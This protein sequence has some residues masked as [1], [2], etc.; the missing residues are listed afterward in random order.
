MKALLTD[1]TM[2]KTFS[3]TSTWPI[4]VGFVLLLGMLRMAYLFVFPLDLSGDEAYYWDWGRRPAWCYYSKPPMIAWLMHLSERLFGDTG[5]GIRLLA[6]ILGTC[7]LLM[8]ALL[9]RCMF[10]ARVAL[11]AV[12]L[13]ALTPANTALNLFLTIDAPLLACW[14]AALYLFWRLADSPHPLRWSIPLGLVL[15]LGILSKQMMLVFPIMGILFLLHASRASSPSSTTSKRLLALGIAT[16]IGLLFLIPPLLWNAQ[17]EWIT[18]QHT[19]H[20]F[21][22]GR[23]SVAKQAGRFFEFIGSQLGIFSPLTSGLL[24][25]VSAC[26]LYQIFKLER[27]AAFLVLFSSPGIL[28]VL[29]LATRQKVQPN[30]PAVYYV[31]AFILLAALLRSALAIPGLGRSLCRWGQPAIIVGTVF[32][33][34]TY[35]SPWI[36]Q[37]TGLEGAKADPLSRLRGWS[38]AGRVLGESFETLPHPAETFVVVLGHRYNASAMAHYLPRQPKVYRYHPDGK[39]DSQYEVWPNPEEDGLLGKDAVIININPDKLPYRALREAF[40]NFDENA[41]DK[42]TVHLGNGHTRTFNAYLAR[43]LQAWPEPKTHSS[44]KNTKKVP[45]AVLDQ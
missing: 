2:L 35:L 5:A 30:W 25:L 44:E 34:L 3:P 43:D 11:L 29:L 19:S 20:H 16:C 1:H 13:C 33:S 42:I 7:S 27:R 18:F 4:T 36:I 17:H 28:T 8:T 12:I 24:F 41:L 21:D 45:G 32:T 6:P 14:T 39:I 38:E 26:G 10:D 23:P 37:I 31:G 40:R 9:A 22:A 15:G